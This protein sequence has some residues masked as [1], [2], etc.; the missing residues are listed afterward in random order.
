M[1]WATTRELYALFLESD[2]WR[3]LSDKKKASVGRKCE[4]CS[5]QKQLTSHHIR[6]RDNWFDTLEEDLRV[7]CWPCHRAKH[8][9][10]PQKLPKKKRRVR[11]KPWKQ[12]RSK[13]RRGIGGGHRRFQDHAETILRAG[14]FDVENGRMIYRPNWK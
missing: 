12:Q 2:W 3:N 8:D 4:E 13:N 1:T 14:N 6:Y 10:K 11:K 7:L 9:D 5:S